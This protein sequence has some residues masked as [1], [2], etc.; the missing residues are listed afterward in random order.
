MVPPEMIHLLT[1]KL[2][3][4]EGC[5]VTK[6]ICVGATSSRVEGAV[7]MMPGC[8]MKDFGI[9]TS[10][11]SA[12]CHPLVW[13]VECLISTTLIRSLMRAL[14]EINVMHQSHKHGS[15]GPRSA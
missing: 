8:G 12:P 15:L 4:K 11:L 3:A 6:T 13:S 10:A 9:R 14:R 5:D 1:V 2:T 7:A